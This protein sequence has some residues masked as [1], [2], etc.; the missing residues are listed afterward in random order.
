MNEDLDAL[1]AALRRVT[2]G[3]SKNAEAQSQAI[4]GALRGVEAAVSELIAMR[5][6][7]AEEPDRSDAKAMLRVAE[8]IAEAIS[9][10]R[11]EAPA[12]ELAPHFNVPQT[13]APTINLPPMQ[14]SFT[15]PPPQVTV[16]PSPPAPVSKPSWKKLHVTFET[17]GGVVRGA[18]IERE[19]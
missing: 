5:E 4:I 17:V 11:I 15:V 14:P 16:V 6:V 12:V 18:S 13:P 8:R 7:A 9:G 3:Q 19:E 10:L 1:Q 2:E